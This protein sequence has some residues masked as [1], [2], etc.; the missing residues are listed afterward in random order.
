MPEIDTAWIEVQMDNDGETLSLTVFTEG[1]DSPTV[2]A[3]ETFDT[4]NLEE[5]LAGNTEVI[6]LSDDT[7]S[8]TEESEETEIE[9]GDLVRDTDAPIWSEDD[10][11]NVLEVTDDRADQH[12]IEQSTI[13]GKTVKSE[14][15]EYPADDRVIIGRYLDQE[16]D[17]TYSF[18]ESRLEPL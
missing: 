5:E 14:N 9:E 11:V 15:P 13:L 1:A 7:R 18:P 17:R 12:V 4:D 10:R 3:I 16:T 8:D 2:E 6:R